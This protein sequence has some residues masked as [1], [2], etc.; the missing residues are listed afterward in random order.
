M[1]SDNTCFHEST[2]V[3]GTCT[4]RSIPCRVDGLYEFDYYET[5]DFSDFSVGDIHAAAIKTDGTLWLWGDGFCGQ[6]GNNAVTDRSSP[7]QT[8]SGGTN[9]KQVSAGANHAAAIKTDGTLWLWGG[10]GSGQLGN[11]AVTDRSSPV[12]TISGGTN[13]KQVNVALNAT[14]AI[15][16]DGTL[17]LWGVGT[18][19]Q[20][21]NN[22]ITDRSSPVQT[23]SVT[24]NWKQVSAGN[25]H[26][27][28]I[29]TD[30][31]LWLW[32]SG[33]CGVLGNNAVTDR[34]SPVQTV[35][36]GTNWKQVSV[37][38]V[39]GADTYTA[40]IKT[41]G[42]LWLWGGGT[43]GRLGNNSTIN[44][45]S[46]VQTISSGTNWKQVSAGCDYTA[47]IKTDGTLWL[48]GSGGLGRLGNN[49]VTDISSPVQT[50][51]GG[52]NW[53]QVNAGASHTAAVKVDNT[54]WIFGDNSAGQQLVS[55]SISYNKQELIKINSS[56]Y[57]TKDY[58]L[59]VYPNLVDTYKQAGLWGWGC[60][61]DG[62]I[63]DNATINRSSPVQTVSGGTNWKQVSA[64]VCHTAAIKTDGS[65]WL[66][67]FGFGG[68]LGNS[69]TAS[70]SSPVQTVSGGTNWKQVSAGDTHTAAI[71][72]DGTLWLWGTAG[73]GSLG[74]NNISNQSSP[75]Q[76]ISGGNNWKQVSAGCSHT[77]AIKTDG[78]LWLW[79]TGSNGR[80]GNNNISN[81]SSPVQTISGGNNWKQVSA[82][83][84]T[85]A[86]IKT[87]GSLWLWGTGIYGQLG[88]NS[89]AERS[90]PVQTV[91]GGTN[92][93]QVSAGNGHTAAIKTDGSLWLWG[94]GL[95]GQL[96]NNAITSR[97]SP[98]Q[99]VSGGNNWKQVISGSGDQTFA[100]RDFDENF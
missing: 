47:A 8:V 37:S 38:N 62:K 28:A 99:T 6:L 61:A 95:W 26:T 36:G 42:T 90:S 53:K 100:I 84:D 16:T 58:V 74:N 55:P 72:T 82:G 76:T 23:V 13:W 54:L 48:W 87:D 30:G 24:T 65:L 9:W 98:V 2:I 63:G 92:W 31:T 11:N 73:T 20:L 10:G 33:L 21:G 85:T 80:L 1:S 3:T 89:T 88:N 77:A 18:S 79:G 93:K 75:V 5:N 7:V 66:W 67:G 86:A 15:K 43:S 39:N 19:G 59:D 4:Y 78:T 51:S 68:R 27:A 46:P 49:A 14:A 91:S 25:A 56:D 71:K 52:T 60:G 41:D 29:K 64:G 45:S 35:S 40:A 17:W 81:Q 44:H 22:A 94:V 57:I 83:Y 50:V 70:Q 32:G 96:G 12:Q 69:S 97:S 34:S